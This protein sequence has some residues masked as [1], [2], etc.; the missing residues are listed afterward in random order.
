MVCVEVGCRGVDEIQG[1]ILS[2]GG[3]WRGRRKA[4]LWLP[5]PHLNKA[6]IRPWA[7]IHHPLPPHYHYPHINIPTSHEVCHPLV[8]MVKHQ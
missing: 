8:Q 4:A 6:P 3:G 2:M 1:I 7:D 5:G